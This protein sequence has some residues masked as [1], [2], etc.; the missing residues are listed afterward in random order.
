MYATGNQPSLTI[1]G[2]GVQGLSQIT[3]QGIEALRNVKIVTYWQASDA[4]VLPFFKNIGVDN[5]ENL[6][7]LY[8]DG[9]HDQ[10][11][12]DRIY[13]RIT[14]AIAEFEHVA[15]FVYGHPRVGISLT[16]PLERW[17]KDN[18]A[19]CRVV[20]A[21]SSFD[22]MCNDLHLDPLERGTVLLDANRL[23]LLQFQIEVSLNYFIYHICSVGTAKT[24]FSNPHIN[25]RLDLL[26]NYLRSYYPSSH[27]VALV[28]SATA[29]NH[30]PKLTQFSLAELE[31]HIDSIDF[32]T[33]LFVPAANPRQVD[34]HFLELL[35][36]V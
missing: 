18:N 1:V 16:A 13:D 24:H 6:N 25:N 31:R 28:S 33:T 12:Y 32:A 7:S 36:T 27:P 9:A 22:T 26:A 11:N 3:L 17:C 19:T 15:F 4:D 8:I 5:F 34:R 30:D 29:T 23:L 35:Q 21:P 2:M 14:A 20:I 10:A